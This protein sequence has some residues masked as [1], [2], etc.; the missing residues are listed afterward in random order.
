[1]SENTRMATLL[2]IYSICSGGQMEREEKEG[3]EED[4]LNSCKT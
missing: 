4:V 2:S 1:M 3:K